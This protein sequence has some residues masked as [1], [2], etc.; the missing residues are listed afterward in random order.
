MLLM[1]NQFGICFLVIKS[2]LNTSSFNNA[3]HC[4]AQVYD[5][6]QEQN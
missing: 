4:Y 2:K 3:L 6:I 1:E 5:L